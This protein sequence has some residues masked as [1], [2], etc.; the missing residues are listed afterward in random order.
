MIV[1]AAKR[2]H[3]ADSRKFVVGWPV[4]ARVLAQSDGGDD[5]ADDVDRGGAD[6]KGRGGNNR[7]CHR[8]DI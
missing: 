3:Q 1:D 7:R 8:R 5:E 6:A 4:R 2:A